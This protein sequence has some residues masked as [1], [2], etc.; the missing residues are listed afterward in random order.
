MQY[1]GGSIVKSEENLNYMM[2]DSKTKTTVIPELKSKVNNLRISN[3]AWGF[4][5]GAMTINIINSFED[6]SI[7]YTTSLVL[8]TLAGNAYFYLRNK[9]KSEEMQNIMNE[10]TSITDTVEKDDSKKYGKVSK[11]REL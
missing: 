7:E 10:L 9:N 3:A 6:I 1:K 2:N 8:L 4:F 5:C 11:P